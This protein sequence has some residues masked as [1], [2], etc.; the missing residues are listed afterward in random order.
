MRRRKARGVTTF[1]CAATFCCAIAT[2]A[3]IADVSGVAAKIDPCVV[4]T[5]A[6]WQRGFGRAVK[7]DGA[8]GNLCSL[9]LVDASTEDAFFYVSA[10]K[11]KSKQRAVAALE[12]SRGRS[13][14]RKVAGLGDEA[15]YVF[16]PKNGFDNLSVRDRK[17]VYT[18][19]AEIHSETG[20]PHQN[21]LVTVARA[22]LG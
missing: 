22:A 7:V 12:N 14:A 15:L 21:E 2:V 5:M 9:S 3:I 13:R 18:F 4:T 16:N 11:Y 10:Q 17:V 20:T 6:D 8:T 19:E 1:V